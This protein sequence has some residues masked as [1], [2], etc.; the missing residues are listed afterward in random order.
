L[1]LPLVSIMCP[2][3]VLFKF[4][5]LESSA[6]FI[7]LKRFFVFWF[8][9]RF[10]SLIAEDSAVYA[11]LDFL[12][13]PLVCVGFRCSQLSPSP[14]P[15][16]KDLGYPDLLWVVQSDFP[17][18][19]SGVSPAFQA[20]PLFETPPSAPPPHPH[21]QPQPPP[22][23]RTP[24]TPKP[25]TNHQKPPPPPQTPP[26]PHPHFLRT[27]SAAGVKALAF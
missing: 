5:P 1:L 7:A 19:F 27:L 12:S 14:P 18:L 10:T 6:V 21:N 13:T 3:G 25:H 15:P 20:Y 22:P 9:V 2:S 23:P 26:P 8:F 16:P 24:P 17:A 4:R 11:L